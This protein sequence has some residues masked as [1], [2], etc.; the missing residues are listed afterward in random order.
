MGASRHCPKR[1]QALPERGS[2][3]RRVS[4]CQPASELPNASPRHR[5]AVGYGTA[6]RGQCPQDAPGG[7]GV[8]SQRPPCF[9]AHEP[10]HPHT[11]YVGLA[12]KIN[13][14]HSTENSEEPIKSSETLPFQCIT[15]LNLSFRLPV[16]RVGSEM[17]FAEFLL[18]NP[19]RVARLRPA[20]PYDILRIAGR[21]TLP[22]ARS[23]IPVCPSVA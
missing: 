15:I 9:R 14:G 4:L 20:A 1:R 22:Y 2:V 17:P 19:G 23:V 11:R 5:W 3:T 6:F 16:P 13:D 10:K 7:H 21:L 12:A 8:L 18:P